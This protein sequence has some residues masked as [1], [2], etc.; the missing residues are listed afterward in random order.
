MKRIFPLFLLFLLIL[1]G[2][3]NEVDSSVHQVLFDD[4]YGNTFIQDVADGKTAVKPYTDPSAPEEAKVGR[5]K[6]WITKSPGGV[7]T[8][9]DF[10]QPVK[11]D[12]HLYAIYN[13]AYT[14]TFLNGTSLYETQL[15][16][17]G[18][19][20]NKPAS[21][22]VNPAMGALEGWAKDSEKPRETQ[23]DFTTPV[24]SDLTLYAYYREAEYVTLLDPEGKEIESRIKVSYG[25]LFP[26]PSITE[27]NSRL[28]EKWQVKKGEDYV[29][30]D[31]SLPVERDLTLKAVCYNEFTDSNI[32]LEEAL[33]VMRFAEVL[34]SCAANESGD[35]TTAGFRNSDL[36]KLFLAA[37]KGVDKTT[38]NFRYFK[39]QYYDLYIRGENLTLPDKI[40]YY[41][42]VDTTEFD[43]SAKKFYYRSFDDGRIEIEA[44]DFTICVNLA[45]GKLEDGKVVKNGDFFTSIP[46]SLT[47]KSVS[48]KM[49]RDGNINITFTAGAVHYVFTMANEHTASSTVS[50]LIVKKTHLT[51]SKLSG[52]AAG[53]VTFYSVTFDPANGE[54]VRKLRL[55]ASSAGTAELEKPDEDPLDSN[56][57]RSF[58]FWTKNGAEFNFSSPITEDTVLEAAFLTRED[59]YNKVLRA[60]CIYRITSLLSSKSIIFDGYNIVD[61]RLFPKTEAGYREM[62]TLLLSALLSVDPTTEKL[63]LSIGD[64]TVIYEDNA[65]IETIPVQSASTIKKNSSKKDDKTMSLKIEDFKLSLQ[66]IDKSTGGSIYRN[67]DATFSIDAE[68]T[69]AGTDGKTKLTEAVLTK[70]GKTYATLRAT[71]HTL[72][73]GRIEVVYEY[74]G[75]K[76]TR[77]YPSLSGEAGE[78]K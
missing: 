70:D 39:D 66:F 20:A 69:A 30:Y 26:V 71:T 62:G 53:K 49:D 35:G 63:S 14:V 5:F 2:C 46:L 10:T 57:W 41:E 44:D 56:G 28:I 29:D 37:S 42:I 78:S 40:L 8:E 45:E 9:Y 50:T 7:E 76:F 1:T 55:I 6:A 24:T 13:K 77:I 54:E 12:L 22:P 60:E 25:D 68:I 64:K 27:C 3:D 36:I 15:I 75:V 19:N 32:S 59:F 4:G 34:S 48:L 52:N 18:E 21:D 33:S 61:E 72:D 58:R 16:S 74:E 11:R 38:L 31:F 73:D 47:L 65:S 43:T 17:D 67:V 51:D 23:Y